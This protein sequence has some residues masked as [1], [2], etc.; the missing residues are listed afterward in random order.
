[1]RLQGGQEAEAHSPSLARLCPIVAR[2]VQPCRVCLVW[3]QA[4]KAET[5]SLFLLLHGP[6]VLTLRA[7]MGRLPWELKLQ[8]RS[9]PMSTRLPPES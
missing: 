1:M 4:A 8:I 5:M 9:H 2:T 6:T 3:A 7:L